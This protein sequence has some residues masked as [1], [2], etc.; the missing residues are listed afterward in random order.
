MVASTEASNEELVQV[1]VVRFLSELERPAVF[2]V[3]D[4]LVRVIIDQLFDRCVNFNLPYGFVLL[5]FTSTW[6]SLPW[7]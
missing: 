3:V 2:Q 6:D 7:K 4:E 1:V 5:I